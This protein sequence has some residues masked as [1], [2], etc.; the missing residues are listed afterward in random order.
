M[1]QVIIVTLF[2]LFASFSKVNAQSVGVPDTLAY[3]QSIVANKAFFI[4]KPFSVLRDSLKIQIKHFSPHAH[5]PYDKNKETATSF[6]F[7]FPFSTADHYLS[8][9]RLRVSWLPYLNATQSDIIWESNNG[10]SW[11][12]N[13]NAFYNNAIIHDIDILQ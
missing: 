6:A 9:P 8:Y 13:S 10:G 1:K 7:Y 11:N 3:L 4:G 2:F 12:T 5:I